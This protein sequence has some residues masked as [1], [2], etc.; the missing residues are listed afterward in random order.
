MLTMSCAVQNRQVHE[1][2]LA[3]T[4]TYASVALNAFVLRQCPHRSRKAETSRARPEPCNVGVL[5]NGTPVKGCKFALDVVC[6]IGR[7]IE[8]SPVG[9]VV[10]ERYCNM[11]QV[12][13]KHTCTRVFSREPRH[14]IKSREVRPRRVS[15][16]AQSFTGRGEE[17]RDHHLSDSLGLFRRRRASP[18]SAQM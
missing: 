10:S 13:T 11:C 1:D 2:P 7:R 8:R 17:A 18:Q 14:A 15:S 4:C 9:C 3:V 12:Q 5:P 6:Q 16:A